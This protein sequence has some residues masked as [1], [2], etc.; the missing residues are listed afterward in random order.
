MTNLNGLSHLTDLNELWISEN[1]FSVFKELKKISNLHLLH[2]LYAEKNP[3]CGNPRYFAVV[4]DHL[5]FLKQ[6][7]ATFTSF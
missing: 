7:D 5:P 4:R 2:T 3:W 6:I 1:E